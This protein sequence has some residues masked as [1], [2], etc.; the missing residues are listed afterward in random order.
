MNIIAKDNSLCF[1]HRGEMVQIEP[2]GRDSLRVRA[3]RYSGFTDRDKAL[4]ETMDHC[5][6]KVHANSSCTC[7]EIINGK[8]KATVN[9]KGVLRFYKEDQ[10]IL[11]EYHRNPSV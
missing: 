9:E 1:A 2:W 4:E 7:G 3:T 8:L 5:Q 10:L 6:A 11:Q